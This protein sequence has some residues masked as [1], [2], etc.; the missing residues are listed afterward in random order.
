MA[1]AGWVPPAVAGTELLCAHSAAASCERADAAV[2]TNTTRPAAGALVDAL[3]GGEGA[4]VGGLADR[5]GALAAA[6]A[7]GTGLAAVTLRSVA[8]AYREADAALAGRM[9]S[10]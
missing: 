5:W 10:P 1:G 4:A 2:H 7:D 9:G 3:G 8:A 6:L